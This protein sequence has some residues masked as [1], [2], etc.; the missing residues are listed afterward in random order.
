[1]SVLRATS[2]LKVSTY[3][4]PTPRCLPKSRATDV[5]VLARFFFS[6]TLALFH[7]FFLSVVHSFTLPH[8][9]SFSRV[10]A[11]SIFFSVVSRR[12]KR[13]KNKP[14]VEFSFRK[15]EPEVEPSIWHVTRFISIIMFAGMSKGNNVREHVFIATKRIV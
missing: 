9:L 5:S 12:N 14:R 4:R 11:F 1:M 3:S 10:R 2:P 6:V 15:E 13:K 8:F 7:S